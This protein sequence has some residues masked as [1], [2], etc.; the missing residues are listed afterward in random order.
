MF[1]PNLY[2]YTKE[3]DMGLIYAEI[4]IINS[5]DIALAKRKVIDI[6]DIKKVRVTA[7]VD[8]GS[9]YLAI[10]ENIQEYLQLP[11]IKKGNVKLANESRISCD[12]V[13]P[14]QID[15]KNRST[16]CDAIVLPGDSELLLGAIPLEGMDVVINPLRQE[17]D[18]NPDS[19]DCATFRL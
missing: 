16:C 10:N 14:V 8:T 12:I 4:E 17:L 7:L 1:I 5:G 13:G 15:F 2:F 3:K 6:D 9:Y 19:P 18:V 11:I